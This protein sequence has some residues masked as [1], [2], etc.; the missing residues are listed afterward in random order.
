VEVRVITHSDEN[1]DISSDCDAIYEKEEQEEEGRMFSCVHQTLQEE[2]A[3]PS[4]VEVLCLL[5]H[6]LTQKVT[7]SLATKL[8]FADRVNSCLLS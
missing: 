3:Y 1:E 2:V 6:L 4:L 7:Y 8:T 5:C